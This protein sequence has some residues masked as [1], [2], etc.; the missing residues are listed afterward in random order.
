MNIQNALHLLS[1]GKCEFR[2]ATVAGL[3]A[4]TW[5]STGPDTMSTRYED[6]NVIAQALG[7]DVLFVQLQDDEGASCGVHVDRKSA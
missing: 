2:P 7:P 6:M 3:V 5:T 1:T 4:S